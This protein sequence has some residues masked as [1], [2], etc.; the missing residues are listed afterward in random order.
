[1]NIFRETTV[2]ISSATKWKLTRIV[3]AQS[4]S[5]LDVPLNVDALAEMVLTGWI[6]HNHPKLDECWKKRES[7]DEEAEASIK[8][9]L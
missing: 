7:A 1:M 2:A 9:K 3:K 6:T 5:D 4:N 8:N